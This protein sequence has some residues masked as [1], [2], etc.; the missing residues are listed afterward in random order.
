MSQT[1]DQVIP[2]S[3]RIVERGA[4][5]LTTGPENEA[6]LV[7]LAGELDLESGPA[8]NGEIQRLLASELET[9]VVDLGDLEFI[10]STGLQCLVRLARTADQ[11]DRALLFTRPRGQ[12]AK[13]FR[14]TGVAEALT[15]A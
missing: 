10:D 7:H 6:C 12:V 5:R 1:V 4:L 14:L 2:P 9:I 3:P 8:L 15:L 13:V 11:R